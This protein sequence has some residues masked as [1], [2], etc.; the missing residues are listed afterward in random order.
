MQMAFTIDDTPLRREENEGAR[1]PLAITAIGAA[2]TVLQ[3]SLA[4]AVGGFSLPIAL[5]T[6]FIGPL[7]CLGSL[8]VSR[9]RTA[10]VHQKRVAMMDAELAR[11]LAAIRDHFRVDVPRQVVID[12]LY[13]GR[14]GTDFEIDVDGIPTKYAA[15]YDGHEFTLFVWSRAE[16]ISRT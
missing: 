8:V 16:P 6:G 14:E 11:C 10:A 7:I 2:I 12:L 5:I 13:L 15:R 4:Y 9:R 3:V 1:L